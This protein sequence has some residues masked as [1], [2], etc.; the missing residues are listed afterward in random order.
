M[1]DDDDDDDNGA[2]D[3]NGFWGGSST[4]YMP[5]AT[6]AKA[7]ILYVNQI[8]LLDRVPRTLRANGLKSTQ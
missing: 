3:V 8:R 4:H 7:S 5:E 2:G 6:E 1:A